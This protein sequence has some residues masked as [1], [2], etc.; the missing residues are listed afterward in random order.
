MEEKVSVWKANLNNGV[1]LALISIVY[2]LVLYFMDQTFNKSLGFIFLLVQIVILWF[3][4]K[5][6]RDT[7]LNGYIT[8]GQSVG[9]G[10]IIFLYYSVITAIFTYILYKFIDSGL[11]DKQ[12]A[13]TEELMVKRGAP[14]AAI[15]ASMNIQRKIMKPE[16]TAPLS[17]FGSM[18][19]GTI[20][21]LIVSI[22][23]RKE[24]NPLI[25]APEN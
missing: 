3:M 10:V 2:T 22:F 11:I 12:L 25:D 9:A 24:G 21:S 13:I 4:I 23:T 18:I 19:A 17:I 7:C 15:D 20:M 8:Y 14:Q 16:I 1:I 6:Y 5:S